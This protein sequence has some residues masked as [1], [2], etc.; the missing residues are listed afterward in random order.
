MG[1]PMRSFP[2]E[3]PTGQAV[4]G[5]IARAVQRC[6]VPSLALSSAEPPLMYER[7]PLAQLHVEA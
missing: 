6:H 5:H 7:G 1:L 3:L 4:G 2:N